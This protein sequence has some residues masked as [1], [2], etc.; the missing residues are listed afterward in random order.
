MRRGME[1]RHTGRV[2]SLSSLLIMAKNEG[3]KISTGFKTQ[4]II[5]L[6]IAFPTSEREPVF[7][8]SE[9]PQ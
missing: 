9:D 8:R 3:T 2:M 4:S 1:G 5:K 6:L 7:H